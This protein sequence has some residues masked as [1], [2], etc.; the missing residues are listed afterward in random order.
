MTITATLAR[1]TGDRSCPRRWRSGPDRDCGMHDDGSDSIARAAA[2]LGIELPADPRGRDHPA[3][4][5][6]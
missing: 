4:Q 6:D 1:C 3:T 5:D 2:E